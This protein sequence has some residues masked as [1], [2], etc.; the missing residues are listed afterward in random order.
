MKL[1]RVV[2]E[3]FGIY[4]RQSFDFD[5]APL[6]LVYG[7]NE[8][9]KTTAL[10]GLRQAMFG[11][12][13]KTPYLVGKTMAAEVHG[14]L[15]D[16]SAFQ[17]SRKKGRKDEVAGKHGMR[18]LDAEDIPGLFG[19]VDLEM[20][21][22][23]FGFT[24]EEL[25]AGEASLKSAKLSEAL[26]GGGMGGAN[27]LQSLRE[28]LQSS[29]IALYRARGGSQIATLLAEIRSRQEELKSLQVLPQAIEELRANMRSALER[30]EQAKSEIAR[31]QLELVRTD[32]LK[33][34][35]PKSQQ[36]RGLIE[37]FLKSKSHKESIRPS[38]RS[39][40]TTRSS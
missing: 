39:G 29:T 40:A 5:G 15:M 31:L 27:L 21:Q 35:L 26:A 17:F 14:T 34:A 1:D 10:N 32:K 33:Q 11:F 23:L 3:N 2:L 8:S 24:L 20:Y 16:G 6:V 30:S 25:R 9:G 19:N 38:S 7:S 4:S 36:L 22:Q 12:P 37:H 28:D 13:M 18:R